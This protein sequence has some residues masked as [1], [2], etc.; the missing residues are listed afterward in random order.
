MNLIE[1]K[2]ANDSNLKPIPDAFVIWQDNL[3]L[4]L[5]EKEIDGYF[6]FW[7]NHNLD[8]APWDGRVLKSIGQILEDKNKKWDNEV[9][10]ALVTPP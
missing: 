10:R 6:Y 2:P 4:G 9:A 5:L 1:V 3:F 7:P 8:G